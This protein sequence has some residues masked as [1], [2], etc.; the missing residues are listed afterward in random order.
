[1]WSRVCWVGEAQ[2]REEKE[3]AGRRA[4]PA[5][6][7]NKCILITYRNLKSNL[8]ALTVRQWLLLV[9]PAQEWCRTDTVSTA[10]LK[11][12]MEARAV[13]GLYEV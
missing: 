4:E 13:H 2:V 3:F 7:P 6:L 10:Q 1:M 12:K 8:S 5:R 9:I 11:Y